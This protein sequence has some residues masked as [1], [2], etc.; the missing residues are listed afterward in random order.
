MISAAGRIDLLEQPRGIPLTPN[1]RRP[2]LDGEMNLE[3]GATLL[4]YTDGLVEGR[5]QVGVDL[6]RLVQ[7]ATTGKTLTLPELCD[8]LLREAPAGDD[9][10]L[11]TIRV[12]P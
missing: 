9:I 7:E 12:D 4:L 2:H 5:N 6:E 11:L 8:N 1:V 3:P 10:V